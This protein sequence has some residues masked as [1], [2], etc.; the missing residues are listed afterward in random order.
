MIDVEIKSCQGR[1]KEIMVKGH[2]NYAR[3]NE[4]VVCAG[5]SSI[6]FGLFNALDIY[7][8]PVK[9]IKTKEEMN[10]IVQDLDHVTLQTIL[11]VG[12]IQL[13]TIQEVYSEYI[14]IRNMEV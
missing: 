3:K 12:V 13:K 9:M 11:N 7:Q 14:R 6:I 10:C 2:A 4:D 8:M 5:V 1:I